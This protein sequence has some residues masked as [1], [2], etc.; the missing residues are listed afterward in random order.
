MQADDGARRSEGTSASASMECRLLD[1]LPAA[2][3]TCDADGLITYFNERAREL[4]GREP[5]LHDPRDR[6]CGSWRLFSAAGTPIERDRGVMALALTDGRQHDGGEIVIE[7]PDGNR[8]RVMASAGPL[9]H[10]DGRR[11]G[12]VGVL[13]DVTGHAARDVAD[14][15]PDPG[16]HDFLGRLAHELR[17]PLMPLRAGVSIIRQAVGDP[18]T[19]G[20]HC[21]LMERQLQQLTRLVNELLDVS[22]VAQGSLRVERSRIELKAVA[23]IA[24][25]ENRTLLAQSEHTLSVIVP[26]EPVL[27][28][29][30]PLRLSQ[31]L[32]GLLNNAAKYTPRG[33][34]IEL[35]AARDGVGVRVSVRDNGLGIPPEKLE[36]IFQMFGRLD[37]SLETG[38]IGLGIGLTLVKA[39]VEMHGGRIDVRS[40]GPGKGSEFSVWLPAANPAVDVV[41]V[42]E[43]PEAG[44]GTPT[45][46]KSW[47]VLLV[48]DNRDVARSLARLVR[49]LGHDIRVAFDGQEALQVAHLFQPHVV[50]MDIGLPKL[51]GYDAAREMRSNPW[52]EDVTLVALTGWGGDMDRQRAHEAGFDRHLTKPVEP[53]VLEALLNE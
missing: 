1:A 5:R 23:R 31:V 20:D 49:S 22:R 21:A 27:L 50:L 4:W 32:S 52:A 16:L 46:G 45:H 47:R 19:I 26:A 13:W 35:A 25:E 33:G 38:Y 18:E 42:P 51:N 14:R 39:L 2:A 9:Y 53:D 15:T 41:A 44:R 11:N 24:V 10:E 43:A 29:A 37:R 28:D 40:E 17:N 3:Y 8:R 12:A 6:F 48:D 36:A 7:R 30:D 34:H